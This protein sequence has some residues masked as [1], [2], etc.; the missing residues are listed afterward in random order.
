MA[1]AI[2]YLIQSIQLHPHQFATLLRYLIPLKQVLLPKNFPT[3]KVLLINRII[4]GLQFVSFSLKG[5]IKMNK[6]AK[7]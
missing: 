4:V 3:V 1:C 6:D 7:E 5:L 2:Y